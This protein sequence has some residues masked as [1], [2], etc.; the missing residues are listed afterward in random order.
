MRKYLLFVCTLFVTLFVGCTQNDIDHSMV[1]YD[2]PRLYAHIEEE[3][4]N[5]R[6]QLNAYLKTVWNHGDEIV[7]VG[8][9]RVESWIFNGEDGSRNAQFS[10]D[11]RYS[12]YYDIDFDD[13]LY[14][15][16]PLEHHRRLPK[17]VLR[18]GI[19]DRRR[20]PH[21]GTFP[22]FEQTLSQLLCCGRCFRSETGK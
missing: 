4:E 19:S 22:P 14:A 5:S 6:V 3:E 21:P 9:Q 15:Q 7:V 11:Y 18:T 16:Y 8:D 2:G 10:L 12:D 1:T 20:D 17:A 13:H